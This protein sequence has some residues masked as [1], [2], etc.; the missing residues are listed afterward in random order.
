MVLTDRCTQRKRRATG[1]RH[2]C[3]QPSAAVH[4]EGAKGDGDRD[5]GRT[6]YARFAAS[7]VDSSASTKEAPPDCSSGAPD[8]SKASSLWGI[9]YHAESNHGVTLYVESIRS[10]IASGWP[11]E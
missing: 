1:R 7:D 3:G 10:T 5:S 4:G 6:R 2:S 8:R 9:H 11:C